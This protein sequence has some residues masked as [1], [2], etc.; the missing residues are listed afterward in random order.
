MKYKWYN[1]YTNSISVGVS[2]FEVRTGTKREIPKIRKEELSVR[3]LNKILS[4]V[5]SVA[6]VIGLV[7][8]MAISSSAA[9]S[10]KLT[11]DEKGEFTIVQITDIQD[12]KE[13]H[14]DAL[15]LIT[16]AMNRYEPDLVVL[17]GDN[18]AG[19]MSADDT[20]SSINQFMNPIINAG[21]PYAVTFG[22]HDA[23][24]ATLI[25]TPSR[26]EQYD[27]YIGMS[28]LAVD[29]DVDSLSHT[30]TGSIPIYSNDGSTVKFAVFPIDTGDYDENGNYDHAKTDQVEWYEAEANR[31]GVPHLVFQHIIVPEV[32]DKL[33]VSVP[34]GTTGS[35]KGGSGQW[36]DR[37]WVLDSS[38]NTITGAMNEGPCPSEQNGG[39]YAAMVRTGTMVGNFVGHDHTNT[40]IGTTSDNITIGYTQAATMHSYGT[41]DPACRVFTVKEDGTYTTK[42]IALSEM[43]MEEADDYEHDTIAG[44]PTVPSRLVVG[45][46]G[47]GLSQQKLG[48]VIQQY[49]VN[50]KTQA[51]YPNDMSVTIDLA[52][53]I[54]NVTLTPQS[55]INV[56]GPVVSNGSADGTVK[57]YTLTITGGTATA[58]TA[59]EF[60]FSYTN[61]D[62]KEMKQYAYSYVDDIR[63][64]AGYYF[65]SRN[66]RGGNNS[67]NWNSQRYVMTVLGDTAYGDARSQTTAMKT[68]K[69]AT[70]QTLQQVITTILSPMMPALLVWATPT[71]LLSSPL[72]QELTL[73]LSTTS[74]D[75]RMQVRAL[76]QQSMLIRTSTPRLPT[77]T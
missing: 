69:L 73:V 12:D 26:D 20:W 8:M 66:Y 5:L 36:T 41:H 40:F 44:T 58:G 29:F 16:K 46:A 47:N 45:A 50:N 74:Q 55:G 70:G 64:P 63:T 18:I 15:A 62:G 34:S 9:Y 6:M 23:E 13:V 10:G 11:F 49:S 19:K 27:Y 37:Y 4:L 53:D 3:K 42:H 33:L 54:T 48:N 60:V 52:A 67:D 1:C 25:D 32:Y 22:N 14:E 21:V 65:F 30:G 59:A 77:L 38:N 57:T 28:N 72:L 56:T 68:K 35:V 51:L 75:S 76:C 7:P 2:N 31:L 39:Q 71:M 24:D 17:T 43:G 61:A